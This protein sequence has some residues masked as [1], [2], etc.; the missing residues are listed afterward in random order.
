MANPVLSIWFDESPIL[1]GFE[2]QPKVMTDI[3]NARD[4]FIKYCQLC[5]IEDGVIL[6]I[7]MDYST[8]SRITCY[9][10]DKSVRIVHKNDG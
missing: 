1:I 8:V 10:Y 6:F 3:V 7:P 5:G 4:F 9:P 2:G